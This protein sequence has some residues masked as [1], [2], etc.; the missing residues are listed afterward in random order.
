MP[1]SKPKCVRFLVEGSGP[2]PLDMLRYDKAFPRTEQDANVAQGSR[3][4]RS[5]TLLSSSLSA[6]THARW[7]SFGWK[8][9]GVEV[10][11]E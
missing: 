11:W 5:V 9:D 3:I 8:V 4:R 6:P 1:R 10:E 2:F 7:E